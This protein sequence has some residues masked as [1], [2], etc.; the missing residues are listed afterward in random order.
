MRAKNEFKFLAKAYDTKLILERVVDGKLMCPE[1]CCGSPV[2]E[3]KCGPDCPHCN[4]HEIQ[5]LAKKE[6]D[7][8]DGTDEGE[9]ESCGGLG[10]EDCNGTGLESTRQFINRRKE[11]DEEVLAEI[12]PIV[13]GAG[14]AAARGA[15]IAGRGIAKGAKAAAPHIKKGAEKAGKAAYHTLGVVDDIA[16]AGVDAAADTGKKIYNKITKSEDAEDRDRRHHP[17]YG[18][19]EY[20]EERSERFREDPGP[21][22]AAG[23]TSSP[24]LRDLAVRLDKQIK[25]DQEKSE[26]EKEFDRRIEEIKRDFK[27][28]DNEE[29][30]LDP[31]RAPELHS[32]QAQEPR[33]SLYIK[34]PEELKKALIWHHG[35][36]AKL[37]NK[38]MRG[39]LTDEEYDSL[40]HSEGELEL[41]DQLQR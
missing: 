17:H 19:P 32:L 23:E 6:E 34:D 10:C 18:E 41:H 13:A 28:E 2:M 37:R 33:D 8:E 26:R 15:A 4:C 5:K 9:C 21:D 14:G 11:E 16:L 39:E 40:K 35:N 12:A 36:Y 27:G 31:K 20:D 30:A 1:A 29:H 38:S 22:L 7:E 24:V 3:C 25:R